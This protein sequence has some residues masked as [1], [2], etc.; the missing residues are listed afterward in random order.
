MFQGKSQSQYPF[1]EP[2][3]PLLMQGDRVS[4]LP[5]LGRGSVAAYMRSARSR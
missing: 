2:G 4:Q 5:S 1:N 3:Y